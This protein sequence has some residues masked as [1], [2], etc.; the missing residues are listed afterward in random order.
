MVRKLR[1]APQS[2]GVHGQEQRGKKCFPLLACLY[3]FSQLPLLLHCSGSLAS[4]MVPPTV[5][6]VLLTVNTTPTDKPMGIPDHDNS[7]TLATDS[8]YPKLTVQTNQ[9]R[10]L[11]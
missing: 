2:S 6:L 10:C 9:H 4:G 8:R 1:E 7:K 5:G 11:W 3:V